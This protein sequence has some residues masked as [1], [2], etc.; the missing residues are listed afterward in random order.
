MLIVLFEAGEVRHRVNV[1]W[2]SGTGVSAGLDEKERANASVSRFS[3]RLEDTVPMRL[4][5]E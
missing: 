3:S 2:M 4:R 5:N 1:V